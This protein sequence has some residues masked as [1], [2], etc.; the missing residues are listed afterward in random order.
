MR[1]T[2]AFRKGKFVE[3]TPKRSRKWHYVQPDIAE[4]QSTDGAVIGSRSTW[5]EHLKRTGSVE[6]GHSDIQAQKQ[7]WDKRKEQFRERLN[8]NTGD[9]REATPPDGEI[10]KYQKTRI[11]KEVA[12]RLDGRPAPDRITLIKLTLETARD[13][14]RRK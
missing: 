6:M 3:I 5:K 12:N 1:R 8:R 14:A 4:F 10:R 13:V 7:K 11:G 2:Y 9:V